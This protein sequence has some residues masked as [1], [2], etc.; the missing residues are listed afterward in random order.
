ML[1][2]L[3]LLLLQVALHI[4]KALVIEKMLTF[5]PHPIRVLVEVNTNVCLDPTLI[6]KIVAPLRTPLVSTKATGFLQLEI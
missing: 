4:S 6:A 5:D 1:V 3:Y 2:S